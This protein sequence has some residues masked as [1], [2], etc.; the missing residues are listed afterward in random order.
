MEEDF[1][2]AITLLNF[3]RKRSLGQT[4]FSALSPE[5]TQG[6]DFR[7][8]RARSEIFAIKAGSRAGQ[9]RKK[10]AVKNGAKGMRC[11]P[12]LYFMAGGLGSRPG[13]SV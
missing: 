6:Y 10:G 7:M 11:E 13:G 3:D 5:G 9:Q 8:V 1:L 2:I 4:L 12:H